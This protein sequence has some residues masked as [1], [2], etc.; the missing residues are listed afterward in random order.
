M[1]EAEWL[2]C[3]DPAELEDALDQSVRRGEGWFRPA[4]RADLHLLFGELPDRGVGPG[5]PNSNC[6]S[7]RRDR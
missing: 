1:T 4:V 6:R 7:A 5:S 2:A 3:G